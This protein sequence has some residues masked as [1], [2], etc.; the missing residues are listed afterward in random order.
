MSSKLAAVASLALLTLDSIHA[1]RA[2]RPPPP[3]CNGI[4]APPRSFGNFGGGGGPGA[5]PP[6]PPVAYAVIGVLRD[7][8]TGLET[9]L[10][11][12]TGK[13]CTLTLPCN[14]DGLAAISAV[15]P[16]AVPPAMVPSSCPAACSEVVDP[17]YTEW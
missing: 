1:Q 7:A 10:T 6:P 12:D 3:P 9:V 15:C 16:D 4:V 13:E 5:P 14:M 11:D 2:A 17:W 8:A